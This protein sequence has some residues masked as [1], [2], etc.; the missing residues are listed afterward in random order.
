MQNLSFFDRLILRAKRAQSPPFRMVKKAYRMYEY[1]VLPPLPRSLLR[2]LRAI[3]EIHFLVITGFR[4]L[5][6]LF[7]RN[8]LFQSRCASFGRNVRLDGPMPYVSG[9]VQIHIGNDCALGGNINISSGRMFDEPRLIIKDRAEIGWNTALVV[10]S[11]IIIE[12]DVRIPINCRI[13]DSDGHPREADR[14]AAN[15][16]PDLK[17]IRPVRICRNAWIGNGSQIM[18][19]VTIGEGA[20][21]G[22]NSVVI[23]NI[24]PYALAMGNPAEIIMKNFGIP[25]TMKKKKPDLSGGVAPVEH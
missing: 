2:P 14:R 21:I 11:E 7:Y 3:Y 4:S 19:G 15:E 23:G 17:D 1:P 24:P 12:E 8:P 25:T 5:I 18:K 22:A 10:N 20:V 9:H 6:T 13:S 16:A